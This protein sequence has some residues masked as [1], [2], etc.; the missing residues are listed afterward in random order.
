MVGASIALFGLD[1][2]RRCRL[3]IHKTVSLLFC[4]QCFDEKSEILALIVLFL[5]RTD[6]GFL[7]ILSVT[8]L[9]LF[10]SLDDS[11]L[12]DLRYHPKNITEI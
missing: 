9:I 12:L 3:L 1:S 10:A 5:H 8:F 2:L 4:L 7:R 6:R 11:R